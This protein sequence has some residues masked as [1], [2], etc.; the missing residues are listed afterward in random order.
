MAA[1]H[2]MGTV[3][4]RPRTQLDLPFDRAPAS[5]VAPP[6]LETPPVE[7]TAPPALPQSDPWGLTPEGVDP[8]SPIPEEPYEPPEGSDIPWWA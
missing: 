7:A 6:A 2:S 5:T 1:W 4:R 3:K 8:D